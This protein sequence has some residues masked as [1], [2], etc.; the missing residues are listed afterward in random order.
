M[1]ANLVNLG[2]IVVSTV[3][4][5]SARTL[6]DSVTRQNL[7]N[8]TFADGTVLY[9]CVVSNVQIQQN[10]VVVT[11]KSNAS[12]VSVEFVGPPDTTQLSLWNVVAT[13]TSGA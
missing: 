9:D 5:T 8:L 7:Y 1:A 6:D 3:S 4:V 11:F 10:G 12:T 13:P 2:T